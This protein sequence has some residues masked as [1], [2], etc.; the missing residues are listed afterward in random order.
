MAKDR[1]A[2]ICSGCGQVQVADC[3]PHKY[4]RRVLVPGCWFRGMGWVPGWYAWAC[5]DACLDTIK[6]GMVKDET[7]KARLLGPA[8]A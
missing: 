3:P 2:R 1:P 5:S 8:G 4:T 6:A 7:D